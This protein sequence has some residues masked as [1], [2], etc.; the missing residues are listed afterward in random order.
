MV[1][2][3]LCIF[4]Q[5]KRSIENTSTNDTNE[6]RLSCKAAYIIKLHVIALIKMSLIYSIR[7]LLC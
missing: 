6:Y 7:G 4:E 1:M 5:L 3:C 2:K